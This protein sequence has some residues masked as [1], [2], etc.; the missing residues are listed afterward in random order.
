MEDYPI[1]VPIEEKVSHL[2]LKR[3]ERL[4]LQGGLKIGVG[5]G[6]W[7]S[8]LSPAIRLRQGTHVATADQCSYHLYTH[9][10]DQKAN[11]KA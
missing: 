2:G 7:T 9:T 3:H 10:Y 4:S 11:F 5:Q 6:T 8:T 1:K